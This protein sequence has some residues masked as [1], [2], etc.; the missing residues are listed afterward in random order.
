VIW[1]GR[2][3]LL[4]YS[5]IFLLLCVSRGY[6]TNSTIGGNYYTQRKKIRG[7]GELNPR[8]QLRYHARGPSSASPTIKPEWYG[9]DEGASYIIIQHSPSYV[10]VVA[11][12]AGEGILNY[13][14]RDP[15]AP[16]ISSG[17]YGWTGRGGSSSTWKYI[18]PIVPVENC[19]VR[20]LEL[21]HVACSKALEHYNLFWG[22]QI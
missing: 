17:F 9:R 2:E 4:Y 12:D 8:S 19:S 11:V 3:G 6:S 10:W 14:I 22:I 16:S 20:L 5:P 21:W 7:R 18:V 13:S 1:K 15:L